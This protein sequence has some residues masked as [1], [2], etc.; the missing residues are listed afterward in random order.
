MWV[1]VAG[2]SLYGVN[3]LK[4]EVSYLCANGCHYVS[5]RLMGCCNSFF[6]MVTALAGLYQLDGTAF[7]Q[8]PLMLTKDMAIYLFASSLFPRVWL[9]IG[10]FWPLTIS[11]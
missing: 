7:T 5:L 2:G 4:D 9:Y 11:F 3:T 10:L 8:L 6:F 1:V